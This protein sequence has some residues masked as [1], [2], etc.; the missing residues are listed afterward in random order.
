MVG[1][2]LRI[3]AAEV[4]GPSPCRSGSFGTVFGPVR[5]LEKRR[6]WTSPRFVADVL[7]RSPLNQHAMRFMVASMFPIR[8]IASGVAV[9]IA[10][11]GPALGQ[12]AGPPA[13]NVGVVP[14]YASSAPYAPPSSSPVQAQGPSPAD[15]QGLLWILS[16][17]RSG[18][19][20]RIRAAMSALSDPL[21]GRIAL[22]ALGEASPGALGEQETAAM[23]DPPLGWPRA[24]RRQI[25]AQRQQLVARLD[26]EFATGWMALTRFNNP[27]VADE[28]FTLLQ[29]LSQAPLTQSRALY[30]R[31]RAA[32]AMGDGVA[33]QLFYSQAAEY[34]TTFYGQLAAART[35]NPVI[36]LGHD[37]VISPADRAAFENLEAV[38]AARL[39]ARIGAKDTF[40]TF[41]TALSE[42]LPTAT[43]VAL[44]VDLAREQGGQTLGMRIVRN[45]AR[46]GLH[47]AG[48]GLPAARHAQDI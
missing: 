19:S 2:A 32:D 3:W 11:S 23:A 43:Q 37:P 24:D 16:N 8:S 29:Q 17:V 7:K 13:A 20:T 48:A 44:L 14:P 36:A 39:L 42:A 47:P 33:A 9:I 25:A 34:P 15:A 35:A 10:A 26:D 6:D 5:A 12:P 40:E 18:D 28:H 4:P 38:R 41:V 46:R 21:A 1:P 27:A 22:W 30:W 45:A 31:G